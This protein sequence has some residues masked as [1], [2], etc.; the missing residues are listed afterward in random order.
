MAELKKKYQCLVCNKVHDTEEAA[1]NC[2]KGPI[3][4][5]TQGHTDYKKVWTGAH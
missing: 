4:G 5:L 2:H 1:R 3:Q